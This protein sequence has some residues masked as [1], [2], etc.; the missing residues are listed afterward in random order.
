MTSPF[1][2]QYLELLER[3]YTGAAMEYRN[4]TRY[5]TT[6]GT[7]RHDML[8][9]FPALSCRRVWLKG[10]FAELAWF[11]RG[12]TNIESLQADGCHIWDQ[13]ADEDGNLGPVYGAQWANQLPGIIR[14]IKELG[15]RESDTGLLV[16]AWNVD[17]LHLMALRPCHFAFQ[18]IP[19]TRG[20]LS[21]VWY[22]RSCDVPV[23]LPFNIASYAALLAIVARVTNREPRWL[24]GHIANAHV[25]DE[26]MEPVAD[27]ITRGGNDRYLPE[28]YLSGIGTDVSHYEIT[29]YNP[30]KGGPVLKAVK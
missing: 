23:G 24:V 6:G 15:P 27:I 18:F 22:Q 4:G 2:T 9:G 29:R 11:L 17:E 3:A 10:V 25:Y 16:S 8:T 28:L 1:E 12:D 26:H 13:W 20:G 19:E 21:L 7:I 5:H 30:R 14:R